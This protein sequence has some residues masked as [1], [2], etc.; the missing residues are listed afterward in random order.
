[1]YIGAAYIIN[2]RG[3]VEEIFKPT[4]FSSKI[5]NLFYYTFPIVHS[6]TIFKRDLIND[7]DQ[8]YNDIKI[9]Q[10]W[11]LFINISRK[12]EIHYTNIFSVIGDV[13]RIVLQVVKIIKFSRLDK[14]K[15]KKRFF[16]YFNLKHKLKRIDLDVELKT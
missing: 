1:M 12:T 5:N 6:S 13:I 7:L 9:G 15:F 11:D 8:I 14:I 4:D 10:D 16:L 2:E 3:E